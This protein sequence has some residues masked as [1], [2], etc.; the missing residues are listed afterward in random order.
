MIYR[1]DPEAVDYRVECEV[2][3][4]GEEPFE[5]MCAFSFRCETIQ[6]CINQKDYA[7]LVAELESQSQKEVVSFIPSTPLRKAINEGCNIYE[8]NVEIEGWITLENEEDDFDPGV[9]TDTDYEIEEDGTCHVVG[10]YSFE[11]AAKTRKNAL[12]NAQEVFDEHWDNGYVDC[13]D[14]ENTDTIDRDGEKFCVVDSY[15]FKKRKKEVIMC[16]AT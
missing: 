5:N 14:I 8:V 12:N 3:Y 6:K 7:P 15:T 10:C 16:G 4:K 9:L 1:E 2:Q 13:G 11:V